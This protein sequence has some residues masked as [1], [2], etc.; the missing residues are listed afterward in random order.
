MVNAQEIQS[1]IKVIFTARD[2]RFALIFERKGK[3]AVDDRLL[4]SLVDF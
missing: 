4:Y 2:A 3:R 1:Q